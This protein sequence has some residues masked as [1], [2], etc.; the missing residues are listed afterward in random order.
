M[1][2]LNLI[3]HSVSNYLGLCD[4]HEK[5]DSYLTKLVVQL[6]ELESKFSDF[7]E[8]IPQLAEKREEIVSAFTSKK[9]NI[10]EN[11]NKKINSLFDA[12]ER[13]FKGLEN[14]LKTLE[15]T[16]LINDIFSNDLMVE[17]LRDIIEN[18]VSLG[19]TTK[20]SEIE[21]K[22]KSLKENAIRQ[23]KDKKELFLDGNT[24]KFGKNNFLVSEEEA[25]LTFIRKNEFFYYHISG[26]D[27][28]E[29]VEEDLISPYKR[30]WNQ[31]NVSESSEIYKAEYMA[32]KV[33]QKYK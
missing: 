27:F 4:T 31:E 5:A 16:K 17:K 25:E 14:R 32:Y 15:D 7:E 23:L 20:A 18:L 6:D 12:A 3:T 13:V 26:T 29:K 9:Q 24:I 22:I 19:D 8:F 21:S 10:L 1:S 30:V 33:F 28:W 11:R 2:K